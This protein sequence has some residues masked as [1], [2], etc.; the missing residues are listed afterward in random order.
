[1]RTVFLVAS[2]LLACSLDEG[3][4]ITA[5]QGNVALGTTADGDASTGRPPEGGSSVS[6]VGTESSQST[7]DASG[8]ASPSSAGSDP[9]E[10][11]TDAGATSTTA[12]SS[13]SGD[14][15]QVDCSAPITVTQHAQDAELVE[16]MMLGQHLGVSYAFSDAA[17]AGEVRFSF[18]LPCPS[19]YRVFGRVRDD[20]PGTHACCDPDSFDV[21]A[22]G[23]ITTTWYYGCDTVSEG[24][25]WGALEADNGATNCD[26]TSLL[27]LTLSAGIHEIILRNR[28][29]NEGDA[30]AGVATLTLTNDPAF[31]PG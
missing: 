15:S 20:D 28:E 8:D 19:N 10:T 29:P 5:T 24:F 6:E 23:G 2:G 14:G 3:S 11:S 17:N 25:S 13:S 22:P 30:R 9:S 31:V 4:G 21:Q 18:E 16:P 27:T 12:G 26:G 7:T 1:M